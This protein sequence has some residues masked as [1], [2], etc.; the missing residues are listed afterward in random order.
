MLS[1]RTSPRP[2]VRCVIAGGFALA[3]A[4]AHRG[5]SPAGEI[6]ASSSSAI[7]AGDTVWCTAPAQSS[8]WRYAEGAPWFTNHQRIMLRGRGYYGGDYPER[9][10]DPGLL[11][12]V[13]SRD[14]VPLLT[15]KGDTIPA[16][17]YVPV[18]AGCI[19]LAYGGLDAGPARR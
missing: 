11:Y 7:V 8:E 13:G 15:E 3:A 10:I 18:R 6:S 17:I 19:F 4:C 16:L 5:L 1:G 2:L 9:H 12:P 14:A